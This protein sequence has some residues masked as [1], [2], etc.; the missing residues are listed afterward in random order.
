LTQISL[1]RDSIQN[2]SRRR[3]N[4]HVV[5]FKRKQKKK[6]KPIIFNSDAVVQPFTVMI[7]V[8]DTSFTFS[9]MFRILVHVMFADFAD[10]RVF[11]VVNRLA[12]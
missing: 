7:K 1:I 9:A 5:S 8:Q 4:K 10:F 11:L 2:N 6:V 3:K 12:K